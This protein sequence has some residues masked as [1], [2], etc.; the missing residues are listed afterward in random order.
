MSR[1]AKMRTLRTSGAPRWPPSALVRLT[2]TRDRPCAAARES[3]SRVSVNPSNTRRS[4]RTLEAMPQAHDQIH[5]IAPIRERLGEIHTHVVQIDTGAGVVLERAQRRNHPRRIA[6]LAD[7]RSREPSAA[8][9]HETHERDIAID[10]I[11]L[12]AIRITTA[13]EPD[14]R[15]VAKLGL[16]EQHAVALRG[17]PRNRIPIAVAREHIGSAKRLSEI[18][19]RQR[20]RTAQGESSLERQ[21]VV[22]EASA[23]DESEVELRLRRH[24][25]VPC[26]VREQPC[27]SHA[28]RS[29]ERVA[30]FERPAGATH[31]MIA[32]PGL[33]RRI[34]QPSG[35]RIARVVA[36]VETEERLAD[37]ERPI[38]EPGIRAPV[39]A[40]A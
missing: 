8:A 23:E 15:V 39:G 17:L 7:T 9:I 2:S 36:R 30:A 24:A 35:P 11:A 12:R 16:A 40:V 37:P 26:E 22:A 3:G 27:V 31:E 6:Y 1:S 29:I 33:Q 14:A 20:S 34:D 32:A 25:V 5:R 4:I 10:A 28:N 13:E 21:G 18:I 19:S 38:I